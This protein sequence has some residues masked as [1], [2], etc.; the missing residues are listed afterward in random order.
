MLALQSQIQ[1]IDR[2]ATVAETAFRNVSQ[3]RDAA[4]SQLSVAFFTVEQLKADNASLADENQLLKA[5]LAAAQGL[6]E[7][8][9][10][11]AIPEHD[12]LPRRQ[13]TVSTAPINQEPS[14]PQ[15]ELGKS[16][17]RSRVSSQLPSSFERFQE[18]LAKRQAE[19]EAKISSALPEGPKATGLASIEANEAQRKFSYQTQTSQAEHHPTELFLRDD[20]SQ[21]TFRYQETHSGKTLGK[22]NGHQGHGAFGAPATSRHQS[23]ACGMTKD[24]I[25]TQD[26]TFVSFLEVSPLR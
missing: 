8:Q 2:K 23:V 10:R 12:E 4:V 21:Q 7:N 14:V 5:R 16:A 13:E 1:S 3:E 25:A 17:R 24:D 19:R 11:Q 6:K 20:R 22:A 9:I 26:V 18:K 15:T